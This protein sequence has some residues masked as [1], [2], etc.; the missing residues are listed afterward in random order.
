MKIRAHFEQNND[1][2]G[3]YAKDIR[4]FGIF[5]PIRIYNPQRSSSAIYATTIHELAHASHWELRKNNWNFGQTSDK[6]IESW[7]TGVQWELTRMKYTN[8]KGRYDRTRGDYTLI[9]SDMIDISTTDNTNYGY[10][11]FS[12]DGFKD[13]VSGYT[14]K[15]IEDVL[16]Y[17]SSWN[18][19]RDNIKN[20]Y[21]NATENKLD[22]LF[23]NWD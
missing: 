6:V 2:N 16:S 5:A 22:K 23:K 20:K 11:Y 3:S 21:S 7:A 13:N 10:G 17:T 15:Q 4:L 19:W 14:L 9:V 8:Y 18:N 12:S 1:K